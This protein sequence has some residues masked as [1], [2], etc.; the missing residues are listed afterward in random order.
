MGFIPFVTLDQQAEFEEF[1]Q[2]VY[3][4]LGFPEEAGVSDPDV[5]FGIWA[6]NAS[7]TPVQKYHDTTLATDHYVW[8]IRNFVIDPVAAFYNTDF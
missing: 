5:G 1:A 7:V 8:V 6:R 3:R 4:Q 2:D